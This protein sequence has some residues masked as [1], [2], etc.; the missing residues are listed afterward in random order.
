[1]PFSNDFLWGAAS[2][3]AQIEGAWDEDG[4]CPSI[5]DVAGDRVKNGETCHI[6]CDHYHRFREDVALM[7][8]LGLN[9]YRFSVSWCRIMPEKGR[10][11]EKG[12]AFYSE[13]VDELLMSGIKP[14][15]TLYHWDLPLWCEQEGGW[16]NPEIVDWFLAYTEAVV[17][18]LSDRV[19]VWMTFNEPQCFLGFG[20]LQGT[21][22]PFRKEPEKLPV[23]VRHYLLAHGRA[24]KLIREKAK[25]APQIGVVMAASC[26]IPAEE[27]KEAIAD[28]VE[29]S[30][31]DGETTNSLYM[32]P[33]GL[34]KASPLMRAALSAED[35]KLIAQPIDFVG[36]NVYQG[37]NRV[38]TPEAYAAEGHPKNHIGW[39]ID[40]R[41]LYWTIRQYWERYH[42]PVMVTE[43]GL[44]LADTLSADG[45]CHDGERVAFLRS[46]IGSAKRA[47]DEGIPVPGYLCWSI[48]DNFEWAKG[49][50][51]RFGLL[52][53]DYETQRRVKKDSALYYSQ[54]IRSNGEML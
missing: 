24:V 17:E 9:S 54:V 18:A 20:Y 10:I 50:E 51:P 28:A 34:G 36:V 48:M 33:I 21:N 46:F 1:M 16:E 31:I 3:A 40:A 35:L 4:K 26:Y 11:N 13:L 45:C 7:K 30:F 32:D 49:Y 8:E 5:W 29:K 6:A 44:S 43:N 42:L 53:V 38:L 23:F 15:C 37:L 22:A 41:C 52:Y 47:A 12:L 2:A 19:E 39:Y 25:T 27:T 14:L